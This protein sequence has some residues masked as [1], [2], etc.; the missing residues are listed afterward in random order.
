MRRS[1]FTRP[2]R[3]NCSS[4]KVIMSSLSVKETR[5]RMMAL[6][7]RCRFSKSQMH[8]LQCICGT[9]KRTRVMP[10]S[11]NSTSLARTSSRSNSSLRCSSTLVRCFTP[12]CFSSS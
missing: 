6:S 7:T 4:R 12:G 3:L 5:E 10:S 9:L 2:A 11:L 1:S 8:E